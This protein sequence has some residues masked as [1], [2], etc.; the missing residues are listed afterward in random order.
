MQRRIDQFWKK[1]YDEVGADL[2]EMYTWVGAEL[3]GH[4]KDV[5]QSA[6]FT[7]KAGAEKLLQFIDTFARDEQAQFLNFEQTKWVEIADTLWQM[8]IDFLGFHTT[9]VDWVEWDGTKDWYIEMQRFYNR[10]MVRSRKAASEYIKEDWLKGNEFWLAATVLLQAERD[11]NLWSINPQILQLPSRTEPYFIE[12]PLKPIQISYE[13][14][15]QKKD[16]TYLPDDIVSMSS[17]DTY[18]DTSTDAYHNLLA[19]TNGVAPKT[20][21][22]IYPS[23]HAIHLIESGKENWWMKEVE[24]IQNKADAELLLKQEMQIQRNLYGTTVFD[25]YAFQDKG[26][27]M[28]QVNAENWTAKRNLEQQYLSQWERYIMYLDENDNPMV[29][30]WAERGSRKSEPLGEFLSSIWTDGKEFFMNKVGYYGKDKEELEQELPD[31]GALDPTRPPTD[32]YRKYPSRHRFS[33]RWKRDLDYRKANDNWWNHKV[34]Y[35]SVTKALNKVYPLH[36]PARQRYV[37]QLQ[38]I[39]SLSP[40]QQIKEMA[41]FFLREEPKV[42]VDSCRDFVFMIYESLNL[43]FEKQT[44]FLPRWVRER[45]ANDRAAAR[46]KR[47]FITPLRWDNVPIPW[48]WVRLHNEKSHGNKY[49]HSCIVTHVERVETWDWYNIYEVYEVG[50][51]EKGKGATDKFWPRLITDNPALVL[52]DW[53][54]SLKQNKRVLDT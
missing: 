14:I 19:Y 29:L 20:I 46:A 53:Y 4:Y 28:S 31:S 16:P 34:A 45:R 23:G 39:R 35:V 6:T 9:H 50:Q 1:D 26:I 36:S 37:R 11:G 25:F 8:I 17:S 40:G 52:Q 18:Q 24:D 54:C 22:E 30:S 3:K 13:A 5:L 32:W 27:T 2:K 10:E 12:R 49:C 51:S 38:Q 41:L 7:G 47:K 44:R 33:Q 42:S 43:Y 21:G 15:P 48:D